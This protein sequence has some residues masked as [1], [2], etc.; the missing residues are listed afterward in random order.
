MGADPGFTN[1]VYIRSG[2]EKIF[3]PSARNFFLATFFSGGTD[4]GFRFGWFQVRL[5]SGSA[6]TLDLTLDLT[7]SFWSD[8]RNIETLTGFSRFLTTC[9]ECMVHQAVP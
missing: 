1:L 7:L 9:R 8:L 4:P 3:G 6:L 5:V 2:L